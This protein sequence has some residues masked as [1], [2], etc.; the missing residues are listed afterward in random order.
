MYFQ[1]ELYSWNVLSINRDLILYVED[2]QRDHR[3]SYTDL[4]LVTLQ[5]P[6]HQ[7]SK[8]RVRSPTVSTC[9]HLRM[10]RRFPSLGTGLSAGAVPRSAGGEG[11]PSGLYTWNPGI[12]LLMA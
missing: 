12:A 8:A 3:L 7:S 10:S 6:Q 5:C 9:Q 2:E 1:S 11:S 4:P